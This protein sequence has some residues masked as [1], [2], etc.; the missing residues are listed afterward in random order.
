MFS[1]VGLLIK[2]LSLLQ[3]QIESSLPNLIFKNYI[4]WVSWMGYSMWQQEITLQ[5][6]FPS[7]LLALGFFQLVWLE[8]VLGFFWGALKSVKG[9]CVFVCTDIPI[10]VCT[11]GIG[12]FGGW[13][14]KNSIFMR[15]DGTNEASAVRWHQGLII[16]F[17]LS[18]YFI[19]QIAIWTRDDVTHHQHR[20]NW[21]E[22]CWAVHW[23]LHHSQ[24]KG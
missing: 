16:C 21:S 6:M 7:I 3:L 15:K 11:T 14:P 2:C 10:V 24:C 12:I 13:T 1:G 23:S 4:K 20:E 8:A 19:A 5:T 9:C 17:T 18:R 22:R